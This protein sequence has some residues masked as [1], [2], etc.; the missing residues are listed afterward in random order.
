MTPP[1]SVR[2]APRMRTFA[3][4]CLL[5]PLLAACNRE[6]P[7]SDR[8]SA[9]KPAPPPAAVDTAPPPQKSI[10][11]PFLKNDPPEM[12]LVAPRLLAVPLLDG[13]VIHGG[14]EAYVSELTDYVHAREGASLHWL[15]RKGEKIGA[16]VGR[17]RAFLARYDRLTDRL[18]D[19]SW[20]DQPLSYALTSPSDPA[21]AQAVAP[22]QVHRKSRPV[23][24]AE[25]GPD[26][27]SAP[28]VLHTLY[29]QFEA[30]LREGHVYRLRLRGG[31]MPD[32]L[33]QFH[34][35]QTRSE[36]IHVNTLGFH[37]ADGRKIA[38]LSTWLGSGGGLSYPD[39]LPFKVI[40]EDSRQPVFEGHA[41]LSLGR[42]S[43]ED[44]T[45]RNFSETDVYLLDFSPLKKIGRYRLVVPGL[46]SS[47]PFVISPDVWTRAFTV[48]TR[49]LF[50]QRSG[51]AHDGRFSSFIKPRDLH[52]ADGHRVYQ[53]G[54][55]LMDSGN[56]LNASGFGTDNFA[57]LLA[58]RTAQAVPE[59]WGGYHDAGDW[60]RRIQHLD[61]SRALIELY[62]LFPEAM[63][64][65]VLDIPESANALPDVID[66][67]LWSMA[68]YRRMQTADGGIRGGIESDN[69]PLSGETSASMSQM[70]M[71][72][73]PDMWSS[74]LYAADAA[75]LTLLLKAMDPVLA[76]DYERSALLAARYAEEALR[77]AGPREL[78]FAVNDARNLM[79]VSLY[80][81][82]GQ[83]EWHQLYRATNRVSDAGKPLFRFSSR[84]ENKGWNQYNAAFVYLTLPNRARDAALGETLLQAFRK[85]ADAALKRI[86]RTGFRW[87]KESDDAWVGWGTLGASQAK[88]LLRA[89]YLTGEQRYLDAAIEAS[90]FALGAN[91]LNLGFT[92]GLGSPTVRRLWKIDARVSG[93][94][95]PE[96]ITAYGPIDPAH[97]KNNAHFN[98]SFAPYIH[99]QAS[100]WPTNENY[101]DAYAI[102]PMN[103]F[104][105]SETIAPNLY[106]W[107]YLSA[108]VGQTPA[109]PPPRR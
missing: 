103:E 49:G 21:Y 18:P 33:L 29:L 71:A 82:T 60:D 25:T 59:A 79:A 93:Q 84:K 46:G 39:D 11:R 51:M 99:P 8:P 7:G 38:F 48:N 55:S 76:A 107:G 65:V 34:S 22:R 28:P 90:Q 62:E 75:R 43:G 19:K 70:L 32:R 95:V 80:K 1:G 73:A 6:L 106:V 41:R 66:E 37:P 68:I 2:C 74:Y 57:C 23:D 14:Q 87:L 64:S 4:F 101:F 78:P 30:P 12:S 44:H 50:H 31:Q 10:D 3:A 47:L 108:A 109:S 56:G 63:H 92:T 40:A 9:R 89:H 105:I 102:Y 45:Y 13:R 24:L 52:P 91:P 35:E 97:L 81:L 86:E 67:A 42:A 58:S 16:L 72:Y 77:R 5:L 104:T 20:L 96:G 94:E 27:Y 100:Q 36:A 54:C 26:S 85:D 83:E 88:N 69:H 15:F 98:K 61:A 53:S 17:N